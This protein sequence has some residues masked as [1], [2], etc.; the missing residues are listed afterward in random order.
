[1]LSRLLLGFL[2]VFAGSVLGCSG[3]ATTVSDPADPGTAA[4]QLVPSDRVARECGLDP[5]LLARADQ[6]LNG[7][8]AV[9]RYGKLCHEH[10]PGGDDRSEE[11]LSASKTLGAVVVGTAAYRTQGFARTDRKT[12]PLSD[13]DRVDHWLDAFD[14]HQDARVAHV[15]AMVAHNEDLSFGARDFSYDNFGLVQINRLNDIITT[16]IAQ[17][18][19]ELGSSVE[20]FTQRF[21]FEPLGMRDS[22]WNDGLPDKPFAYGWFGTVRDMARLGLL[23]LNGG[24]W[25]G[26]RLLEREWTRKIT[27]PAFED[28]NT[29]YSY[30]TWVHSRS[31]HASS[32]SSE[33]LQGPADPC[34]PAAIWP[35]YPHGL[36][37]SADCGYDAPWIC[38]QEYDVGVWA[39]N[40]YSGHLIVG[41]PGL[42]MV[43]IGKHIGVGSSFDTIWEAVRPALVALDPSFKGDEDAF[44]EAYG[45]NSYAP[46]L[47]E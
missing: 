12:G 35:D 29:G 24:T 40:G 18:P 16:A 31:N 7:P 15:L 41:H 45:N 4:W 17:D 43:L 42:D 1:M 27:H 11:L 10:Y 30:L 33:R 19:A 47:R 32:A 36:S 23:I 28:S 25:N 20:E 21:L 8:Y 37:E 44:C 46:D 38:E 14:F 6:A 34:S 39:A 13:E 2:F 26:E 9:V 5:V 3:E 22:S